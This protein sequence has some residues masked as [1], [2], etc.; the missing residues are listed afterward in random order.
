MGEGGRGGSADL[1]ILL[2]VFPAC[3]RMYVFSQHGC[4]FLL[5]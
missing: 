3:E 1:I 4:L 5:W 2:A